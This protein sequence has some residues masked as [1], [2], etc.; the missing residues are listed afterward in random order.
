MITR[1]GGLWRLGQA[2]GGGALRLFS[3]TPGLLP[4]HVVQDKNNEAITT[5]DK[6]GSLTCPV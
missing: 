2:T 3:D 5:H 4:I 1:P 6:P